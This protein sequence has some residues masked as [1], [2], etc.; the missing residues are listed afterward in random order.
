MRRNKSL[1][2]FRQEKKPIEHGRKQTSKKPPPQ[3]PGTLCSDVSDLLFAGR[4]HLSLKVLIT[5][6]R[7]R[8]NYQVL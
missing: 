7:I 8:L 2:A 3:F 1:L 6:E 4:R 5:D